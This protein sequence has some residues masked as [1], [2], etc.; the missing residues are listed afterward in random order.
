M[1]DKM[2]GPIRMK[3]AVVV[4]IATLVVAASLGVAGIYVKVKSDEADR[5]AARERQSQFCAL[6]LNINQDRVQRLNNTREYLITK[7]GREHT[8]LNDYIRTVSLPRTTEE[9]AEERL[10]IPKHCLEER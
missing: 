4:F 5:A 9:V 2:S 8:P 3:Y 1:A 6:I 7:A 10:N